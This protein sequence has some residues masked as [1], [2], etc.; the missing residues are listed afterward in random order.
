MQA[1]RGAK[2]H[3]HENV[4]AASTL[5]VDRASL[6]GNGHTA[7][8]RTEF[9]FEGAHR[10]QA[11]HPLFQVAAE[12]QRL[13][14]YVVLK[15]LGAGGMGTVLE[16]FDR[17]LERRVAV[18]VLHK[19]IDPKHT[20]RLLREAQAMAK[21]SHPNVVQVFDADAVGG[22]TFVAMEL[23]RG[24][25]LEAWIRQDPPPG[26]RACVE[27]FIQVGQGLAAA[28]KQGL[29]HRDFKPS[30]AIIDDEGRPRVLDFGL[31]RQVETNSAPNKDDKD[32]EDDEPSTLQRLR[33]KSDPP[34]FDIPLTRTGA[35]LG[36]PAYMPPEQ[37]KGR[38]ADARSDQFSFCVSLY[39]AVYGEHPFNG[40]TLM[41]LM[42]SM[43]RGTVRPAPKGSAVPAR[44]RTVLLRGLTPDPDQRWPSMEALITALRHLVAPRTW[45]WVGL[46]ITIGLLGLGGAVAAPHYLAFQQRCTGARAQLNGIWDDARRGQ[47]QAAILGTERSF[48]LD[49]W[50]RIE[51]R[52]DA[53]A[54]AWIDTHTEICKATS[55]RGEQSDSAMDLRMRC[56]EQRRTALRATIDVLAD[57]NA[58]M[59]T[60]TVA[61]VI[62]LP[63]LS[64][65]DDLQWLEQ[66]NRRVPPPED[67]DLADKVEAQRVRLSEVWAMAI[68]GR[69]AEALDKSESVSEQ[70]EALGYLPL[71][72]EAQYWRGD[73]REKNGQYA[74]AEQDLRQAY[75]LAVQLHHD[76]LALDTAQ[77]LTLLVGVRLSRHDAGQQ[78]GEMDALP[79]AQRSGDLV[80]VAQSLSRLGTVF[81]VQG[82]L[83]NAKRHYQRALALFEK[84]LGRD[85]LL[86]AAVLN[87]LGMI[88]ASQED[89]EDARRAHQRAL[90]IFANTLGP[91]HPDVAAT[92]NSMGIMFASQGDHD[93]ARFHFQQALVL[94]EKALGPD[95]L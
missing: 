64:R 10:A 89:F 32:G 72:A 12:P 46:G 54:D 44:L 35:I 27:V 81:H 41:G 20:A 85:H 14:R 94:K 77:A 57:T 31:V 23:V 62:D 2:E 6:D 84:V 11:P 74:E 58:Q 34:A 69:Y 13:G 63:M 95:H 90:T 37:M 36:T 66:Q 16:A 5:S 93:S 70:A 15:T 28:H 17:T 29:V 88:S 4:G 73:L 47:V 33:S 67:P 65:C 24:Q 3:D 26:W 18:K 56:L 82:E 25:T 76:K 59:V 75:A 9:R 52:L 7:R 21:L 38:E 80:E 40:N 30:N 79:L 45:R 60:N 19:E 22:Q 50:E 83:Q 48:A 53:Y 61:L 39:Q 87:N 1:D 78:W 91:D 71:R 68:A 92:L 8:A 43:T 51:P 55:V 42:A 86:V 49:T